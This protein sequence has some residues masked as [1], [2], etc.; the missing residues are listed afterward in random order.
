MTEFSSWLDQI[1][2]RSAHPQ[3]A[4][5]HELVAYRKSKDEERGTEKPQPA[6]TS[7]HPLLHSSADCQEDVGCRA[8]VTFAVLSDQRSV[9]E[10]RLPEN[11]CLECNMSSAGRTYGVQEN[12]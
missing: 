1:C 12:P 6:D 3:G 7:S 10:V 5:S 9:E 8:V 11:R 2:T 4:A